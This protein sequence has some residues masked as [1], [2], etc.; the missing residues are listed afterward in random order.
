MNAECAVRPSPNNDAATAEVATPMTLCLCS[1][2]IDCIARI[3]NSFPAPQ[4][5][6]ENMHEVTGN[7]GFRIVRYNSEEFLSKFC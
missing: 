2:N 5:H 4:E 1:Q 3:V 7:S 6:L